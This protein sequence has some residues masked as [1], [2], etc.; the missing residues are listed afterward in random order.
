MSDDVPPNIAA[1]LTLEDT[2]AS[3]NDD[4]NEVE[5]VAIVVAQQPTVAT[6]KKGTTRPPKQPAK[7]APP[8]N[9]A[10]GDNTSSDDDEVEEVVARAVAGGVSQPVAAL[11]LDPVS[12]DTSRD[13]S[14]VPSSAARKGST[15]PPKQ[16]GKQA[17][18]P[19]KPR[20]D[21]FS[22]LELYSFLDVV[23]EVLP[24]GTIDWEI[25]ARRHH[26]GWPETDRSAMSLKNKFA[27]LTGQR[28]RTGQ[29]ELPPEV[30][31][32]FEINNLIRDKACLTT[33]HLPNTG[34]PQESADGTDNQDEDEEGENNL[35][36][37]AVLAN[38]ASA[39]AS[40]IAANYCSSSRKDQR[41]KR[42][43]AAAKTAAAATEPFDFQQVMAQQMLRQEAR[44]LERDKERRED[45]LRREDDNR[46]RDD[47]NRRRDAHMQQ[48]MMFMAGGAY[49]AP[50]PLS[51]IDPAVV[52]QLEPEMPIID[53][54]ED[55]SASSVT[56]KKT[57]P[58]RR[59]SPR[60][61][62]RKK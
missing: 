39:P 32:A 31:E 14:A 12:R 30:A 26:V 57:P 11:V 22:E 44:E 41:S 10:L 36:R 2:T 18:R 3:S 34:I 37:A 59:R 15:R 60:T 29:S 48:L 24:M 8:S 40:I 52:Q 42:T 56:S 9:K 35:D 28:A 62:P 20:G 23:R 46:R 43:A 25:V 45:K 13:S 54:Q 1:N 49:R 58:K 27:K 19:K 5:P 50:L 7:R 16:P 55:V 61:S 21:N 4:D 6:T 51:T 38:I 33:A 47:D 53:Q 17:P